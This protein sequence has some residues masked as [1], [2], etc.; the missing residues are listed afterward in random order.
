MPRTYVG[1]YD[2]SG[3]IPGSYRPSFSSSSDLTCFSNSA[4][5]SEGCQEWTTV[6]ISCQNSWYDCPFEYNVYG[7]ACQTGDSASASP[8]PPQGGSSSGSCS[9]MPVEQNTFMGDGA[10]SITTP[11]SME[12]CCSNCAEAVER[13]CQ[14]WWVGR[15]A[16][17]R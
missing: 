3:T 10:W 15:G 5:F 6:E 4:E 8:P 13:W 16:A 1:Y 9:G 12:Q 2:G 11:G 7:T 14:A 17:P